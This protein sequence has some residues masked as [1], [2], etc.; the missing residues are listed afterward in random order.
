MPS[1]KLILTQCQVNAISPCNL[2]AFRQNGGK[3][4]SDYRTGIYG[5]VGN[6]QPSSTFA[7]GKGKLTS[8]SEVREKNKTCHV[9]TLWYV[10][11][12]TVRNQH[13]AFLMNNIMM[14]PL[15]TF[16]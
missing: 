11:L 12:E 4:P 9:E 16:S 7:K 13:I 1:P 14:T 5:E 8:K 10:K 3:A 2:L 15:Y 6:Q